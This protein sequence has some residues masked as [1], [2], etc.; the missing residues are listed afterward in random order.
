[1]LSDW[2]M[3]SH[4][5]SCQILQLLNWKLHIFVL[6]RPSWSYKIPVIYINLLLTELLK[7]K[8]SQLENKASF[9]YLTFCSNTNACVHWKCCHC[10]G[11]VL[12]VLP[13]PRTALI[14]KEGGGLVSDLLRIGHEV[15]EYYPRYLTRN[16]STCFRTRAR[17]WLGRDQCGKNL[18]NL[19]YRDLWEKKR[20]SCVFR[21]VLKQWWKVSSEC[22]SNL[23]CSLICNK[24]GQDFD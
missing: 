6:Y 12:S 11:R 13:C 19:C 5:I 22:P 18:T 24:F 2:Q 4:A 17:S 15:T 10:R 20:L 14:G 16:V 1:M 23:R 9:I 8:C 7:H 3:N 21:W